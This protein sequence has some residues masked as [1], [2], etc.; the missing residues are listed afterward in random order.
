MKIAL[1]IVILGVGLLLSSCGKSPS[2]H[3]GH[4]E[5][6]GTQVANDHY[7]CPMHPDIIADKPGDCPK[8]GMHL[9]K[10][11]APS[12]SAVSDKWIE[13]YACGMHPDQLQPEG[14][15]CKICGCG[16]QTV[17]WRVEKLL[18]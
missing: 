11:A 10:K 7:T 15:E 9:V 18:A 16:M 1:L 13:G 3:A 4:A 12:A 8:C 6:A 5:S 17:K 2:P 14:G